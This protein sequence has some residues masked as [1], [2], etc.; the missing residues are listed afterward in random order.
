MILGNR[1]SRYETETFKCK[2]YISQL[3]NDNIIGK[4]Y[5]NGSNGTFLMYHNKKKYILIGIYLKRQFYMYYG[6]NLVKDKKI[7]SLSNASVYKDGDWEYV[8]E[9]RLFSTDIMKII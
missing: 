1:Y 7:W 6:Y 8:N 3:F 9:V 5:V 2:R 4:T